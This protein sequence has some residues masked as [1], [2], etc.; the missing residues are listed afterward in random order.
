VPP[1]V[2][3]QPLIYH[4]L[5][6]LLRLQERARAA[7]DAAAAVDAADAADAAEEAVLARRRHPAPSA[8]PAAWG[9]QLPPPF[10]AAVSS[11]PAAGAQRD[12]GGP[13]LQRP[14]GPWRNRTPSFSHT[15][16]GTAATA[17]ATAA[18]VPLLH[19]VGT[20]RLAASVHRAVSM[21]LGEASGAARSASG[22][23]PPPSSPDARAV[24]LA[25]ALDDPALVGEW[26]EGA[27]TQPRRLRRISVSAAEGPGEAAAVVRAWSGRSLRGGQW[28]TGLG[29]VEDEEVVQVQT[30]S[31]GSEESA[32]GEPCE[33]VP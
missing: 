32:A 4:P 22:V 18:A 24:A 3:G 29:V 1:A 30:Q 33:I 20:F 21:R 8:P 26:G 23:A 25:A 15:Q 6:V 27:A 12:T 19:R 13:R 16:A 9:A 17:A 2:D 11:P 7:A 31:R 10:D 5:T 28:M 14:R